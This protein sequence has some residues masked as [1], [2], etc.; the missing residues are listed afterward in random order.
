MRVHLLI[1]ERKKERTT[2]KKKKEREQ[3]AHGQE[4]ANLPPWNLGQKNYFFMYSYQ[5]KGPLQHGI[6][7]SKDRAFVSLFPHLGQVW[8]LKKEGKI[9]FLFIYY[10]GFIYIV[11]C[12]DG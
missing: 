10:E 7:V 9:L 11:V 1:Q 6:I 3:E 4:G 8:K 2:K 12:R 5:F